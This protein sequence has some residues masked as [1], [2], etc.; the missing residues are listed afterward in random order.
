M[1]GK[2]RWGVNS[3]RLQVPGCHAEDWRAWDGLLGGSVQPHG[4]IWTPAMLMDWNRR[5][6]QCA[7]LKERKELWYCYLLGKRC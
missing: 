7:R 4:C 3:G 1:S 2:Q 5:A 6:H